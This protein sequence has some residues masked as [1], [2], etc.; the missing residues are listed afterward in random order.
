MTNVPATSSLNPLLNPDA[1]ANLSKHI[2]E[3]VINHQ[4]QIYTDRNKLDDS[5]QD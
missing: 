1:V 5:K 3:T 4:L 2:A